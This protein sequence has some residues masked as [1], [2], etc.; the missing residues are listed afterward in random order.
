MSTSLFSVSTIN[1]EIQVKPGL[2]V[3]IAGNWFT[4]THVL[5]PTEPQQSPKWELIGYSV[6]MSI[7]VHNKRIVLTRTTE[8]IR[9]HIADFT[10]NQVFME[11][12]Q[13]LVVRPKKRK[14]YLTPALFIAKVLAARSKRTSMMSM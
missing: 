6:P 12:F 11:G 1:P 13:M 8:E 14:H 9:Q 3:P 4:I 10:A 5:P 2:R 7:G